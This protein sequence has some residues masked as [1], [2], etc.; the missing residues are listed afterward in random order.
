MPR[1]LVHLPLARLHDDE[2]FRLRE[3]GDVSS[4]AQSIAQVGQLFPVEV[5]LVGGSYQPITG[6]RRIAALRMLLRDKV[7][8]RVH[9]SLG[10]QQAAMLAAAD[11]IDN[12]A[13]EIEEL[14]AM[15]AKYREAGWANAATE[16]LIQRAIE[17]AGERLEDLH[18]AFRG[19]PPPDRSIE[20]ED[21]DP[22]DEVD[23]PATLS[24]QGP[25][26]ASAE[27]P[28]DPP[29]PLP[30]GAGGAPLSVEGLALDLAQRLSQASVDLG[31]LMESWQKVPPDLLDLVREQIAYYRAIDSWL[32]RNVRREAS[33]LAED[34][35]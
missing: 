8:A 7:L 15:L 34:A 14:S 6:F 9:P 19:E 20:D 35:S 29:I 27:A 13:L 32:G 30:L 22:L 26:P 1:E 3:V 33:S 25:P 18:A 23:H 2:T 5:R 10:D 24:A 17:K 21:G 28:E 12:R 31:T 16:E 11:A 4:L